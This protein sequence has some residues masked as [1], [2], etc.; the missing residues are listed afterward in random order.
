MIKEKRKVTC[1]TGSQISTH[2]FSFSFLNISPR[3]PPQTTCASKTKALSGNLHHPWQLLS[4]LS[5]L[6]PTRGEAS[7]TC[8]SITGGAAHKWALSGP[9]QGRRRTK[10]RAI[11]PHVVRT[12]CRSR[13]EVP[14]IAESFETASHHKRTAT[15]I[16]SLRRS[17]YTYITY[18]DPQDKVAKTAGKLVSV[19]HRCTELVFHKGQRAAT[20][21]SLSKIQ[22][23][24][25]WCKLTTLL[26]EIYFDNF[27]L[28]L[29]H[30]SQQR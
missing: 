12:M 4:A 26:F 11:S 8:S 30:P 27:T 15:K 24:M 5:Q 23:R 9:A 14:H 3:I 13:L 2:L 17:L 1:D 21:F 6:V 7:N 29:P 16:G 22:Q 20:Y 18:I 10:M 25:L 19:R 28:I